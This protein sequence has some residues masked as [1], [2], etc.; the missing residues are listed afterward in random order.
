LPLAV[1]PLWQV[2]QVPGAMPVCVNVAGFHPVVRWQ[3]S[4]ACVVGR[5]VAGLPLAVDPL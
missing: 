4:Q 2:W 1:V 3:A 5:C